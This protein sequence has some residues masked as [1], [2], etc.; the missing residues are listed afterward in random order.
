MSSM[1]VFIYIN[2]NNQNC[3]KNYDHISQVASTQIISGLDL[4]KSRA[5]NFTAAFSVLY[6][7]PEK[8]PSWE[9]CC[10]Q[11]NPDKLINAKECCN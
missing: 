2:Q 11:A 10:N 7:Y 6:E 5:S 1:T 8:L 4:G 3:T 9:K